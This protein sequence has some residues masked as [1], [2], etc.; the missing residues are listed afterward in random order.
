MSRQPPDIAVMRTLGQERTAGV[1]HDATYRTDPYEWVKPDGTKE[2]TFSVQA[3]PESA[4]DS[5]PLGVER[6]LL[7]LESLPLRFQATYIE[8]QKKLDRTSPDF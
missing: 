7:R 6:G 8:F 1:L 5:A 3:F 4:D 2:K